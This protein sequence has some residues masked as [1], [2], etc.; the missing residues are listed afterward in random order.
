MKN[1]V[2]EKFAVNR[3]LINLGEKMQFQFA[4]NHEEDSKSE[5]RIF[6]RYLENCDPTTARSHK[7][8]L[9]WL[10]EVP[11]I[12]CDLRVADGRAEVEY[13]PKEP[14][15]YMAR[16]RTSGNTL[17]RYFAVV[18]REYLVYRMLAYSTMQ[19]PVGGPEMRNG[20]IPI[21]W[22]IYDDN[23]AEILA[24]AGERLRAL[25]GFQDTFGDLIMPWLQT[26]SKAKGA[27]DFNIGRYVDT[28][29]SHMRE[30]G[31]SVG[32]AVCDW[33]VF[34]GAV[35]EYQKRGFDVLD[36]IIPQLE[37]QRG[38]PWFP[39]WISPDDFLAPSATP[40]EMMAMIMD[41]C[42]GFH[43]HG[44]PDFH[45]LASNCNWEVAAPHSDLAVREHILIAKNS[46]G[47]PVFIPTLLT[48]RYGRWGVW[49]ERNW[50]E[51][52]QLAFARD[53]L[54]DTAFVHVRKYPIAFARCVDIADYRR[55][56]PEPQPRR[57]LSSITH[58]WPYDQVWTAEW[59]NTGENVH[60]GALPFN[61][62]LEN[63]RSR[64]QNIIWYPTASAREIVYYE[65]GK[66]QCRFEYACPK[67]TLWY[68]YGD[69]RP[70]GRFS[71]RKE[72]EVPDPKISLETTLDENS[73][74]L[75]YRIQNGSRF[76]EYKLVL[77]DIPRE[78][79]A[80]PVKTSAKECLL[81]ENSDGDYRAILIF[82]LQSTMT[83]W[84]SFSKNAE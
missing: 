64:Q 31:I 15:N 4:L 75:R 59:C 80:C 49:P 39:Y 12:S 13:L 25:L 28:A 11:S 41:F 22:A 61:E 17:Y 23:L 26:G 43:F 84:V 8:C 38:A 77:W 44:P 60:R 46:C 2:E 47:G 74:E 14:G 81:V 58:D 55:E 34:S 72:I 10:E 18:T 71:G 20:G 19:P 32:R 35:E 30:A 82:D 53:F 51:E 6:P 33:T 62:S 37:F 57:V 69:H 36:G 79:A 5:F 78:F 73:L 21:D 66:H 65:D 54:D 67:P 24:P 83:V 9:D 63:I 45:M 76:P 40:T 16:L 29:I 1:R 52:K 42:I 70:R 7:G 27:P 48:F 56:H 3:R 50:P 68:D